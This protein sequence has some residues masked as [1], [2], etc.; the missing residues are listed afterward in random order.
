MNETIVRAFESA[1]FGTIRALS[2]GG[3]PW[4]VAKDVC[5]ALGIR[6]DTIRAILDEDEVSTFSQMESNPNSIGVGPEQG[7]RSPL[8]RGRDHLSGLQCAQAPAERGP[9]LVPAGAGEGPFSVSI[10]L[11]I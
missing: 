5:D 6:T 3:E 7:G 1:Q 10:L 8:T 11:R 2:V 9:S 4:F